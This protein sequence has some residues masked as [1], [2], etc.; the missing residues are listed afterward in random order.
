MGWIFWV[1]LIVNGVVCAFM[2]SDMAEAKGYGGSTTFLL[3]LFFGEI[4]LLY[5]IGMP[6]SKGEMNRLRESWE[7][8]LVEKV[9]ALVQVNAAPNATPA[10][11]APADAAP[12]DAAP[13]DAAPAN[14]APANA[15]ASPKYAKSR[16]FINMQEGNTARRES[17]A[18]RGEGMIACS[19]CGT[20]QRDNRKACHKCGAIFAGE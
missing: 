1:A 11:A 20:I 13:A 10:D 12:A 14:A 16:S 5:Y 8:G 17:A 3:G 18:G 4:G 6:V 7:N 9:K 19:L 2:C 15:D